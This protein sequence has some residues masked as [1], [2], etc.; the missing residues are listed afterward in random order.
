[1]SIKPAIASSEPMNWFICGGRCWGRLERVGLA[2]A[3]NDGFIGGAAV[4]IGD[5]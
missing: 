3:L 4:A 1:M 5:D 2:D